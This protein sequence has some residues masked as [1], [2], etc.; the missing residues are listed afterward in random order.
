MEQ[1]GRKHHLPEQG[2]RARSWKL[3][4]NLYVPSRR[5]L[6]GTMALFSNLFTSLCR[7]AFPY[8]Y[9]GLK[10]AY[11]HP[12][13]TTSANLTKPYRQMLSYNGPILP[14]SQALILNS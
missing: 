10:D 14:M 3:I 1:K 5:S 7:P 2:F 11:F 6:W 4:K 9:T 12:P 13:P 8:T